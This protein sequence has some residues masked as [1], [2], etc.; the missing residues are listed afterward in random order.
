M[1][2]PRGNINEW[3]LETKK[4]FTSLHKH[5]GYICQTE[6]HTDNSSSYFF[7]DLFCKDVR[8]MYS[9]NNKVCVEERA[10]AE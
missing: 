4:I 2:T 5:L 3:K 9:I 6:T 1:F 7:T 8:Y 10:T